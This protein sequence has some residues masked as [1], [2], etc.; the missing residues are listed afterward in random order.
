MEKYRFYN[1]SFG[2][3]WSTC[4]SDHERV[5]MDK[6]PVITLRIEIAATSIEDAIQRAR[7]AVALDAD[8]YEITDVIS[9]GNFS[10]KLNCGYD[11]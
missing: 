6:L 9:T 7:D 5:T 1:V 2:K 11:H 4:V 10:G 3:K 8:K